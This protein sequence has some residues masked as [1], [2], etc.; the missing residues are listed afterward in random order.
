MEGFWFA[1]GLTMR[2]REVATFMDVVRVC[3]PLLPGDGF[4]PA[5][6]PAFPGSLRT[7]TGLHGVIERL[8]DASYL[9]SVGQWTPGAPAEFLAVAQHVHALRAWSSPPPQAGEVP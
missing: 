7:Y 1:Q 2:L 9:A 8:I 6:L 4:Q 3:S 5:S